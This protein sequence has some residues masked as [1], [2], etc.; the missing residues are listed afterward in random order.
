MTLE[1]QWPAGKLRFAGSFVSPYRAVALE[2]MGTRAVD[3][4]HIGLVHT[5]TL[6]ASM[7]GHLPA[8]LLVCR[9]FREC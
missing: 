1:S 4:A 3:G 8:T 2:G 7:N 6:T 9:C 5:Y